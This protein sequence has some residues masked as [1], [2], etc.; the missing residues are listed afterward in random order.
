MSSRR[1][2]IRLRKGWGGGGLAP[3]TTTTSTTAGGQ[4]SSLTRPAWPFPSSSSFLSC[5]SLS[6]S[7]SL[8]YLVTDAQPSNILANMSDS[9]GTFTAA[10][11]GPSSAA[12]ASIAS[13]FA[14]EFSQ[15]S[16][17]VATTTGTSASTP[18]S[19]SEQPNKTST[20]AT[21]STSS[22]PTYQVVPS[23]SGLSTAAKAGIGAGAAILC[24][25]AVAVAVF[26]LLWKK[27][28][29]L[30]RKRLQAPEESESRVSS[31]AGRPTME[32]KQPRPCIYHSK[33]ELEDTSPSTPRNSSTGYLPALRRPDMIQD[34][35]T[36]AELEVRLAVPFR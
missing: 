20:V 9:Q 28:L 19:S 33:P 10:T 18:K 3:P 7:L 8:T 35:R 30:R 16:T 13:S 1:P 27:R 22:L 14:S 36:R 2:L 32:R 25:V 29:R 12:M 26:L 21:T 4:I 6:L 34:P 15:T 17:A 31:D 11:E 24:I 5:F 23:P